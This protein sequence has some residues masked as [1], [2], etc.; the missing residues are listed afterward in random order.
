MICVA[1]LAVT[2]WFNGQTFIG[3]VPAPLGTPYGYW[4]LLKIVLL[5]VTLGFALVNR[6]RFT[7]ALIDRHGSQ[8]AR[9]MRLSV[10]MEACVGLAIVL[11]AGMLV[12][13]TPGVHA[14]SEDA[15][16]AH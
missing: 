3:S 16:H 1:A 14:Q 10:V 12:T 8:A 2:A 15:P 7:P 9:R 6:F 13:T 5:V 11:A 4:A